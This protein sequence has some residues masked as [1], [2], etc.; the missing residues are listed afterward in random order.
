MIESAEFLTVKKT[1]PTQTTLRRLI[2]KSAKPFWPRYQEL[3]SLKKSASLCPLCVSTTSC[4]TSWRYLIHRSY[5]ETWTFSKKSY[6]SISLHT[7]DRSFSTRQRDWRSMICLFLITFRCRTVS[8]RRNLSQVCR[9]PQ[10]LHQTC[11]SWTRHQRILLRLLCLFGK[12]NGDSNRSSGEWLGI[13]L[14]W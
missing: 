5:T 1:P 13:S 7:T 9:K 10:V 8:R 12:E 4:R 14:S 2:V 6:R 3:I 11:M